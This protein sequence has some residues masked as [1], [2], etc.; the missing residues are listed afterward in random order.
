MKKYIPLALLLSIFAAVSCHKGNPRSEILLEEG[1][2]FSIGD[3]DTA[4]DPAFD[5]SEWQEVRIPHDWAIYGPFERSNDLQ[6]VAVRQND[7]IIATEI[8]GRTGG[9]PYVG[10]GGIAPS[11]TCVDLMERRRPSLCSSMGL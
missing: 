6:V 5:D 8:T 9:L 1:W 7:E 4:S 3:F 10:W 11:L 2:K